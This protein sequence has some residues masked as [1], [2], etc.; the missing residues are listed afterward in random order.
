MEQAVTDMAWLQSGK[1]LTD[2]ETKAIVQFLRTLTDKP[3][4]ARK[5][6]MR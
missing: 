2:E 3:R 5:M 4:A 6:A 1:K